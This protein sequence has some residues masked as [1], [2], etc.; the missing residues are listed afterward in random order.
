VTDN[1]TAAD[2]TAGTTTANST[3]AATTDMANLAPNATVA[4]WP[5]GGACLIW[6]NSFTF[7][8]AFAVLVGEIAPVM[9]TLPVDGR[10]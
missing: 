8:F 3:N 4:L 9:R 5:I 2:A 7:T 1:D 10:S 6:S